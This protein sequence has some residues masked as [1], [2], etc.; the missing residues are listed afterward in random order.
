[1]GGG[2]AIQKQISHQSDLTDPL[3]LPIDVEFEMWLCS[4]IYITETVRCYLHVVTT[5]QVKGYKLYQV[6]HFAVQR[7]IKFLPEYM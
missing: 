6:I 2:K 4:S 5:Y 7:A 3:K 1:M